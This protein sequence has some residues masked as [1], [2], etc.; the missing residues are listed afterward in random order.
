MD[1]NRIAYYDNVKAI[2]IFLVVFGHLIE[3]CKTGVFIKEYI[4]IYTFHMPVFILISGY[5]SKPINTKDE[6]FKLIKTLLVPYIFLEVFYAITDY[7]LY[8]SSKHFFSPTFLY[9][10]WGMW[11]LLSLFIWR[12]LIVLLDNCDYRYCLI[13][14]MILSLL[15][16]YDRSFTNTLSMS[17]T[18]VFFPFFYIGYI[19]KLKKFKLFNLERYKL[20]G[21]LLITGYILVIYF[22]DFQINPRWFYGSYGY[23]KL[24]EPYWGV[25]YRATILFLTIIIGFA[26]L[27]IIPKE[28]TIFTQIGEKTLQIY[29]FHFLIIDILISRDIYTKYNELMCSNPILINICF[30]LIDLIIIYVLFKLPLINLLKLKR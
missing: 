12:S 27:S 11:Y 16:G 2:L 23:E 1:K 18:I 7:F 10:N 3:Q 14:L 19:L 21:F 26:F 24:K 20:I 22:L 30:I 6:Y 9:P 28:K 5:F 4:F 25:L 13:I 29:I 8:G 15:V 17:R